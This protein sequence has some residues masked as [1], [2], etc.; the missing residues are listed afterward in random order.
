MRYTPF[1]TMERMMEQFRQDMWTLQSTWNDE[2]TEEPM[3]VTER[4][5]LSDDG[6]HDERNERRFGH[7]HGF[8]MDLTE[9]ED[10]FVFTADMPGFEKEE[11]DLRIVDNQLYLSAVHEE[12]DA[13]DARTRSRT[14]RERLALPEDIVEEEVSATYKN[15]VL[16]VHLPFT[17]DAEGTRHNIEIN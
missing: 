1:E 12:T 13:D 10:E 8:N 6:N 11:I 3:T 9:H 7:G 14:V 4:R 5:M 17:I 16:E 2:W 15:G